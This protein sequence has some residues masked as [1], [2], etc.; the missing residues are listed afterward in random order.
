MSFFISDALAVGETVAAAVEGPGWQG[1]AFPLGILFFFYI[2]FIRPQQKKGKDQKKMIGG[3]TKGAEVVTN[4][5]MLGRVV[6]LDDNFV[7]LDVGNNTIVQIQRQAIQNLM[8]K[9]TFKVQSKR[10]NNS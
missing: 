3:L 9:G 4:G 8:P 1:L 7:Q 5:G 2:L 6:S 10:L